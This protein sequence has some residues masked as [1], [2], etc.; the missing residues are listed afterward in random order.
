[1]SDVTVEI[2]EPAGG[3]MHYNTCPSRRRITYFEHR[4][5][6]GAKETVMTLDVQCS[7][8]V[9]HP[10]TPHHAQLGMSRMQWET[11]DHMAQWYGGAQ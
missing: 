5:S 7:M 6:D 9:P 11:P 2:H 8:P 10:G 3:P 1:M 4:A